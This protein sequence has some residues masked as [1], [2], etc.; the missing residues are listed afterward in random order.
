MLRKTLIVFAGAAALSCPPMAATA[1]A[2]WDST[3][4]DCEPPLRCA[5]WTGCCSAPITVR[6]HMGSKSMCRSSR[7][8]FRARL[9]ANRCS[10]RQTTGYSAWVR[11]ILISSPPLFTNRGSPER[12]VAEAALSDPRNAASRRKWRN[13]QW[14]SAASPH[15]GI[16]CRLCAGRVLRRALR[17]RG[18]LDLSHYFLV[19]RMLSAPG[20]E[21]S[22]R[23]A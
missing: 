21:A 14:C 22:R 11:S 8:C 1:L 20:I 19:I 18:P 5:A 15:R 10:G 9:S 12:G 2:A 7:T 13:G 4:S 3:Q 23:T 6:S 17:S 16:S